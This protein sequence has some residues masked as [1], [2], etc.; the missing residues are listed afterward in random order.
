MDSKDEKDAGLNEEEEMVKELAE[1]TAGEETEE[2]AAEV[3]IDVAPETAKETTEETAEKTAAEVVIDV[4]P[5]T[6]KNPEAKTTPAAQPKQPEKKPARKPGRPPKQKVGDLQF[7]TQG[8]VDKPL[9]EDDVFEMAYENPR[10]FK[11]LCV[12]LK[13]FNVSE[14]TWRFG[15]DKIEI[16]TKDYLNKSTVFVTIYGKML[17]RYYCKEPRTIC[18]KRE[19]L[20]KVFKTIAKNHSQISFVLKDG[21]QRSILYITV[22]DSELDVDMNYEVELIQK[23]DTGILERKNDEE[24]PLKFRLPSKHFKKLVTD[25]S[26]ASQ[27]FSIAK[28]EKSPLEITYNVMKKI[29]LAA[30]YKNPTLIKLKSKL[31]ADDIFSVSVDISYIKPFSNSNIGEF[32]TIAADKYLPISFTSDIDLKKYQDSNNNV[33][34]G[35]VC[36]IKVFTDVSDRRIRG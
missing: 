17:I 27:V 14:L 21:D 20:E 36:T 16:A 25:I 12:M 18:V 7:K 34:E 22:R 13:H 10:L 26:A 15:T 4:A 19:S 5:Q 30:V 1:E 32:V 11:Q 8:I 31:E 6:A 3:V 9:E 23:Q 2:T 33:V 29:N 24:Y 35:P 28:R